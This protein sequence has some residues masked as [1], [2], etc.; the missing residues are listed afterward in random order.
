V[1]DQKVRLSYDERNL[2]FVCIFN[3]LAHVFF[4]G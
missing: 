2:N 4:I 1:M 3:P